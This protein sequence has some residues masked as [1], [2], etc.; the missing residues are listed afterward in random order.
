MLWTRSGAGRNRTDDIL[1]AKQA[2][3]L[4]SY[5]PEAGPQLHTHRPT[6]RYRQNPCRF[7][8]EHEGVL[9]GGVEPPFPAYQ[10]SA[11]T[12]RRREEERVTDGTRTRF[13]T[14]HNRAPRLLRLRPPLA[15][16][17]GEPN[18]SDSPTRKPC[19]TSQWVPR[20]SFRRRSC[21]LVHLDNDGTPGLLVDRS[22][23]RKGSL[24]LEASAKLTNI[25]RLSAPTAADRLHKH[26]I[27]QYRNHELPASPINRLRHVK[28]VLVDLVPPAWPR[29][30]NDDLFHPKSVPQSPAPGSNRSASRIPSECSSVLSLQGTE[31][32]RQESNL[33]PS[34]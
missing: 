18:L 20:T 2:L 24:R 15:A 33:R 26:A 32:P 25:P 9:P 29:L 10:A 3:S 4:L 8:G 30:W 19:G 7:I 14:D 31:H 23:N 22:S 16:G 21:C 28:S 1:L 11:L 27:G 5:S 12:V 6:P 34:G 17:R 13:N